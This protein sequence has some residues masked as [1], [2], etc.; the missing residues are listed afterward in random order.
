MLSGCIYLSP[1]Q[2]TV[3][4]DPADGTIA[5]VGS[6]QLSDVLVVTSAKGAPGT[7]HGMVTNNG[8]SSVQLSIT[9]GGGSNQS[10][11]IPAQTA[12]RLDG[13]A[14]GNSSVRIKPVK[15]ANVTSAPGKPMTITFST[16]ATG[17]TPVS[18]PVLLDQGNYGSASPTHPTYSAP[19]NG[20]TTEP[21]G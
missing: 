10:V 5:T 12:V 1:A 9:P 8:N 14:S 3:S 11:T 13:V 15:I 6:V 16:P 18:V 7:L 21:N 20:Q 2:T 19:P 17:A 4:Y